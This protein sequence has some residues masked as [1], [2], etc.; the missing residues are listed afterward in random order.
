MKRQ[1]LIMGYFFG[2]LLVLMSLIP[3]Y[4]HNSSNITLSFGNEVI[5][6]SQ[7]SQ[8]QAVQQSEFK[9]MNIRLVKLENSI[10]SIYWESNLTTLE[11]VSI[12]LDSG[13]YKIYTQFEGDNTVLE[14]N[15]DSEGYLITPQS[16]VVIPMVYPPYTEGFILDAPWRIE[17]SETNIPILAV[18][19][20]INWADI[21]NI[22]VYDHYNG[23]SLVES[24]NWSSLQPIY[25]ETPFFHLFNISKNSFVP[26]DGKVSIKI[27]FDLHFTFDNWEGPINVQISSNDIPKITDWYCGDTHQHTNYTH[28]VYEMGAPIYATKAANSAMGLDWMIVTDHSFDLNLDKWNSETNECDAHSD[29]YFRVIQGEE[30]SCYLPETDTVPLLYQYNH[31]LVYN[32]DFILG[33]EWQDLTGSDYTPA[34]VIDIANSQGGITYLAH[35]LDDDPFRNPWRQNDL[36]SLNFTGLQIWNYGSDSCIAKLEKGIEKWKELLLDNRHVYVEGGTDAHGDFNT[37]AGKVKTYVSIPGYSQTSLPLRSE[38]LDALR[39]GNSIMTDGPIV[40]FDIDGTI[41]GDSRETCMGKDL[42]DLN[43]RWNTTD[44]FGELVNI[45]VIQGII[46]GDE[47]EIVYDVYNS[48]L[49]EGTHSIQAIFPTQDMYFRLNG[50]SS[51][52]YRVYTNPIWL[53][54]DSTPPITNITFPFNK[55]FVGGI[56]TLKSKVIDNCGVNI[57]HYKINHE[58]WS[59]MN[60]SGSL[61]TKTINTSSYNDGNY[62][63]LV[64]GRDKENNVHT[65]SITLTFDNTAPN[66]TFV[67][68]LNNSFNKGERLFL[69]VTTD[70][71]ATCYYNL[72]GVEYSNFS[73]EEN[74]TYF[75]EQII[76]LSKEGDIPHYEVEV[77][78]TDVLG[79]SR[80]ESISF[81]LDLPPMIALNPVSDYVR[82]VVWLYADV[83]DYVGLETPCEVCVSADFVCDTEWIS[84]NVTSNFSSG[85]LGGQCMYKWNTS[86]LTEVNYTVGFRIKDTINNTVSNQTITIVDNTLPIFTITNPSNSSTISGDYVWFNVS[87]DEITTCYISDSYEYLTNDN[88]PPQLFNA[89]PTGEHNGDCP[90]GLGFV[91]N[92][93]SV[94]KG[95]IENDASYEEMNFTFYVSSILEYRNWKYIDLSSGNRTDRT[96]AIYVKCKD[97]AGNIMLSSYNWTFNVTYDPLPFSAA[98][99]GSPAFPIGFIRWDRYGYSRHHAWVYNVTDAYTYS[100]KVK[101]FDRAGNFN[102]SLL[103]FSVDNSAP[104]V[105]INEPKAMNYSSMYLTLN[106][107]ADEV[108]NCSYVLNGASGAMLFTD[109]KNGAIALTARIGANIINISCVDR[110]GNINSTESVLFNVIKATYESNVD[111]ID[112][113][114]SIVNASMLDILL[115]ISTS[116]NFTNTSV[117]ITK[118]LSNPTNASFGVT[119]IGKYIQIEAGADLLN[120]VTSALIK[121]FYTDEE[122]DGLDEISLAVYWYNESSLGWIKLDETM[123]WVYGTGVNVTANYV[124]ANVSHFSTYGVGG[125]K[126]NGESCLSASECVG[127]YCVHG[128]CRYSS[129]YC[130]D[131]YCDSGETCSSCEN[132]CGVCQTVSSSGGSSGVFV[133]PK[134]ELNETE[135]VEEEDIEIKEAKEEEPSKEIEDEKLP[136]KIPEQEEIDMIEEKEMEIVTSSTTPTGGVLRYLNN[137]MTAGLIIVILLIVYFAGRKS[138]KSRK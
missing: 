37:L 18:D 1:T 49:N 98:C 125:Q 106:V 7:Y 77:N 68:P 51:K 33:G 81:Y 104:Q 5:S 53:E 27:K 91:T 111:I 100:R 134:E 46:P 45:T 112:T 3:A 35:P 16:Q 118:T 48:S 131:S 65:S 4:A 86:N 31:L 17:N 110:Y 15:N 70:E 19:T 128:V 54:K 93:R 24:T 78:C 62:T 121:I 132:D 101:C 122:I 115:E 63:I 20:G 47:K 32:A 90:I 135:I 96:V 124:W 58:S 133:P 71:N 87:T 69:N 102:E 36:D 83:F 126:P 75:S 123:D 57:V 67:S 29:E 127:G 74:G 88:D 108:A 42:V 11:N 2:L 59:L 113:E 40:V 119:E 61:A 30:V 10:E 25:F 9:S 23:D 56:I 43:I 136:E 73:Y 130:G 97:M 64:E 55:S 138:K 76:N 50:T 94:C 21:W 66:I 13:T 95:N 107:S 117:N 84:D 6:P 137:P 8:A 12:A 120:N 116:G 85:D 129:T 60:F 80:K 92:E 28:N 105:K 99:G 103:F 41:I 22:Y 26:V 89:T 109:S 44:E 114:S 52:G 39:N 79:N 38:I 14:Y 72:D 82:G 34:E